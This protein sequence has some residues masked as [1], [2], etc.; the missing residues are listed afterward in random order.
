[1]DHGRASLLQVLLEVAVLVLLSTSTPTGIVPPRPLRRG[2]GPA[3]RG[4]PRLP[5]CCSSAAGGAKMPA[6]WLHRDDE[7]AE[8]ES[9]RHPRSDAV[10]EPLVHLIGLSTESDQRVLLAESPQAD[11]LPQDGQIGEVADPQAIHR[12][13]DDLPVVVQAGAVDEAGLHPLP[14]PIRQPTDG[15]VQQ[16]ARRLLP[17]V[18][19]NLAVDEPVEGYNFDLRKHVLEYDDVVNKQR[20]VVY[21]QRRK[22]LESDDLRENVL[23]MVRE[24][25]AELVAAYCGRED[26]FEDGERDLGGLFKELRTF[27]PL[28]PD[29][30]PAAWADLSTEEIEEWLV[31]VA[32]QAYD[33]H[34][35]ALGERF[36][37]EARKRDDTLGRLCLL[38]TSPS[39]RD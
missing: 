27:L 16:V 38:Y 34:Y 7:V 19:H 17:Q 4:G 12:A 22:V 8:E 10:Q 26:E 33:R 37:E 24:E 13:Q 25:I 39:P 1:M 3:S 31:R 28:P 9:V 29:T 32:E 11:P 23:R 35:R 6:R 36:F 14:H 18:V 15:T 20:E 30:S 5:S 2:T 21:D